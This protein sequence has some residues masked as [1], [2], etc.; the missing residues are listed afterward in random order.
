MNCGEDRRLQSQVQPP[1]LE[2][3]NN[4]P[5]ERLMTRWLEADGRRMLREDQRWEEDRR[6][7]A[8]QQER[9]TKLLTEARRPAIVEPPPNIP[10]FMLQKFQ[11]GVDDMSSFQKTFE[12]AA[13]AGRCWKSNGLYISE[14]HFPE[15]GWQLCQPCLQNNKRTMRKWSKLCCRPI[16]CQRKLIGGRSLNSHL[17]KIMLM[18]GF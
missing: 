3:S 16:K 1:A 18:L 17:T 12:V 10:K 2:E 4:Y 9:W 7:Q 15:Q 5:L 6:L 13:R 8:Q 14:P 11:E